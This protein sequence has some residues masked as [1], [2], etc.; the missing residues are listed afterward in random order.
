MYSCAFARERDVSN[1]RVDAAARNAACVPDML[2][3]IRWFGSNRPDGVI[4]RMEGGLKGYSC[5][6]AV[7]APRQKHN[8]DRITVPARI[9]F[10]KF[11]N[12]LLGTRCRR[13]LWEADDPVVEAALIRG[14]GRSLYAE[15][16]LEHVGR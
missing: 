15:V 8:A 1:A 14:P 7:Q 5:A 9:R 11:H 12:S 2:R 3:Q 6:L 13:D 16:P 10:Q 4:M